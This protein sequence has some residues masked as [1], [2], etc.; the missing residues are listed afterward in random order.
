MKNTMT[1]TKKK[2]IRKL[3]KQHGIQYEEYMTP[4]LFNARLRETVKEEFDWLHDYIV[5]YPHLET[6]NLSADIHVT[7]AL[8]SEVNLGSVSA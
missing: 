5:F 2:K 8:T 4:T 1:M 6:H 7:G 3:C